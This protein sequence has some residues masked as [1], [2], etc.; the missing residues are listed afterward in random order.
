MND[1]ELWTA[2]G[3]RKFVCVRGDGFFLKKKL[4]PSNKERGAN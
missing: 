1:F 2:I 4:N 3:N